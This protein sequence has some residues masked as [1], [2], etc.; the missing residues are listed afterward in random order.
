MKKILSGKVVSDAMSQT[1]VVEIPVWK[2][3]RIFGKRYRKT[4]RYLVHNPND[5]AK[6]GDDV[7]ITT[8]KPISRHKSWVV[9]ETPL[10]AKGK[11]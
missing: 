10:V 9:C 4:R 1:I 5:V 6:L 8:T 3:H 7:Q 2:V 11:K